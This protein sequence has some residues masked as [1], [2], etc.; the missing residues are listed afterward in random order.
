M[1][2]KTYRAVKEKA[3]VEVVDISTGVTF[4]KEHA[5]AKF[6]ETVELH[7]RLGIDASKSDQMVRG[8]VVLPSG[9]PKQLRIAVITDDSA[10]QKAAKEAGATLVGGEELIA[11][12]IAKGDLDADVTIAA[13][14]MMPKIAKAAK[15]LG[16]KGLMPNPKT[17][18]VTPD[19]EAAVKELAAGK[20]SFKMDSLGNIHEAVGKVSWDVQKIVDNIE[21]VID[22][23]RG[24][25]PSGQK[26]E[27]LKSVV[28][29]TTMG[30]GVRV[31]QQ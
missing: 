12:I 14:N 20:L 8:S 31:T 19:V 3:P 5:R 15:I 24:A 10:K 7:I 21:A 16:P 2:G 4:V 25:K 22:A 1:R 28:V 9:A 13:P 23:V 18:T 27:F 30:P 26:G 17:G 11:D 6:D 29:S